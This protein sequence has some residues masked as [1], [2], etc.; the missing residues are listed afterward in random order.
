MKRPKRPMIGYKQ[1]ACNT[2]K[3]LRQIIGQLAERSSPRQMSKIVTIRIIA[4]V[5]LGYALLGSLGLTLAI[6]P[7]YASPV[8][9]AAGMALACI[10]FFDRRALFGVWLGSFILNMSNTWLLGTLNPTTVAIN[11]AIAIGA[12]AQSWGGTWLIRRFQ[13]PTWRDLEREQDTFIFL[14]WGG[15]LAALLLPSIGV[16]TLYVGGVINPADFLFNWWNWY[17]GDALGI[18]VFA[19]LTLCLLNRQSDLWNQRRRVVIIPM[20]LVMVLVYIAFYGTSR[21]EKQV[22]ESQFQADSAIIA[23]RISDRLITHREVLL[24]LSHFIEATPNFSFK[25]FE[26]FTR[27]TL[28]DNPD[29][30]A[31]SFNDI[32]SHEQRSAYE[33]MMSKLSPLGSY[34]ITE[35]DSQRNLIRA[36][37]REEYVA[38][39]YIV[40][41]KNNQ[42][43]VGFDINSEPVRHSAIA[44]AKALNDMAVTSPIQ[45]VQEQKKR[46]GLLQLLPVVSTKQDAF[47]GQEE[48]QHGFAVG[49]IKIDEAIEIATRDYVSTGLMFQ[50]IDP[51]ASDGL[52]LLYNS[53]AQE[54]SHMLQGASTNWKTGLRM[55][56]REW[57]LSISA[58]A[59]YRQKHRPWMAWAV[60]VAGLTF[61]SLLQ[62]L[63]FG[64]TGRT[65]AIMS[66]NSEIQG[67]ANTLEEKVI[68]RTA[69]LEESMHSY[70][71]QVIERQRAEEELQ[72]ANESLEQRVIERT[73]ELVVLHSQMV[74]QEKMASV[75]QLA[76]GIAHELNNPINF[77]RTNFATLADNFTDL[78]T[79]LAAYRQAMLG[80]SEDTT[81]TNV[82]E[83]EKLADELNIEYLCK[84]IPVLLA[85]SETGFVR[86]AKIIQAMRDFSRVDNLEAFGWADINKGLEDT[87]VIARNEYRYHAEVVKDYGV[88]PEICCILQQLNQVF[89]NLIVN[90]SQALATMPPGHKGCITIT[91]R[92]AGNTV[93]CEIADNGPGIAVSDQ[94]RIFE[95][96][97]TTKAPGKGTGLGLSISYDIVVNKHHGELKVTCPEE[98]GAIFAIFLPVIQEK[99]LENSVIC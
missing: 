73:K 6:P 56:D 89:L 36:A 64:M 17:V 81:S 57:V 9:P 58:T 4:G 51:Q 74:M 3:S 18:L 20:L 94:H 48:I 10:L 26:H 35:R 38:V 83:L 69:E 53:V 76:A 1:V 25:Q 99:S 72:L 49:V 62:I 59:D 50:L 47:E 52:G 14:L 66:K 5:A 43:A 84:D 80:V 21:W 98:G 54:D 55:G 90:G 34:Q 60:G 19:P 77:V 71:K 63:L 31:L 79:M 40:P 78:S 15:T 39:R 42:P 45:L 95:P 33:E 46:V 70:R 7:G 32:V 65:A 92:H 61:T 16:T 68:Q 13:G 23:K 29:I 87:L 2:I 37:T 28:K 82:A 86:I 11:T 12:T 85:E 8:F 97:F 96:F 30:F 91:T 93:I 44:R 41:L 75:G 22:Q 67:L 27:A 24:S 88:L